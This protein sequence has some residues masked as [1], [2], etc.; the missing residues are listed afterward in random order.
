MTGIG[1]DFLRKATG[2]VLVLHDSM[3]VVAAS[4][5]DS[6]P[7]PGQDATTT[8]ER[9]MVG[10]ASKSTLAERGGYTARQKRIVH[11]QV[12]ARRMGC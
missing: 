7:C 10:P 11:G 2:P 12:T 6:G 9:V 3:T 4:L 8:P 5:R 1:R